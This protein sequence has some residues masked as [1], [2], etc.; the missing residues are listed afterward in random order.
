MR[1]IKLSF[2]GYL[3]GLAILWWLADLWV[4][5]PAT[6]GNWRASFINFTGI[7]GIAVMSFAL[8]LAARPVVL[9]PHRHTV[10]HPDAGVRP[11][12]A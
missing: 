2:W 8:M 7:V 5:M 4:V 9:E 11:A 12:C 3:L 10:A 1:A 6:F